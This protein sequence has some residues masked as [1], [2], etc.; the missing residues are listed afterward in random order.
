MGRE[1][2]R[3]INEARELLE[4]AAQTPE[5]R[6]DLRGWLGQVLEA[7]GREDGAQDVPAG[8]GSAA[9]WSQRALARSVYDVAL[10]QGGMTWSTA[11]TL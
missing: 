6:E 3:H 7:L 2:R 4:L 1:H 8:Q 11:R 5:G 10:S 9:A